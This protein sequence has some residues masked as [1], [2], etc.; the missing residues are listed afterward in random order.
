MEVVDL[1]GKKLFEVKGIHTID[2]SSLTAGAYILSAKTRE[3]EI[4]RQTFVKSK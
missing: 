4:I 2:V 1:S 3:G